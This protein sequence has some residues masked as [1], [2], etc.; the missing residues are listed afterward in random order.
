M[1]A[2]NTLYRSEAAAALAQL[3]AARERISGLLRENEALRAEIA[4]IRRDASGEFPAPA[5]RRTG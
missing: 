2:S 1:S 5:T 4:R 3:D